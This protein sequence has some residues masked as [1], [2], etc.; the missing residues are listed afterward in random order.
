MVPAAL[1]SDGSGNTLLT[2]MIIPVF[3]NSAIAMNH[4]LN[5]P[6]YAMIFSIGASS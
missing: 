1:I 3:M 6:L 2:G 5:L 4:S